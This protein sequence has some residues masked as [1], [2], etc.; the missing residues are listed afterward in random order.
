[1]PFG[2]QTALAFACGGLASAISQQFSNR[3]NKT[4][5]PVTRIKGED[6]KNIRLEEVLL[7][8]DLFI[9]TATINSYFICINCAALKFLY[10]GMDNHR[11]LYEMINS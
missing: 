3:E 5:P 7:R 8:R 10:N 9:R 1:M 2:M 6:L 11:L 4:G